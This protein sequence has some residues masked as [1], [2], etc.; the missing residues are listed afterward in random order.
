MYRPVAESKNLKSK[1][2]LHAGK[3]ICV[4]VKYVLNTMT[5]DNDD[6]EIPCSKIHIMLG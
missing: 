1:T 2:I 5:V 6:F 4:F 3:E